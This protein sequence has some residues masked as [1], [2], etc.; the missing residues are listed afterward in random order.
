MPVTLHL[1][2]VF[3]TIGSGI[4]DFDVW[5]GGLAAHGVMP[6]RLCPC[7]QDVEV[8]EKSQS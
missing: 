2:S 4:S 6:G 5:S 1:N 8:A 7:V 3:F